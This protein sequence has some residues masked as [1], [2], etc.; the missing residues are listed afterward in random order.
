VSLHPPPLKAPASQANVFAPAGRFLQRQCTCGD[1]T[2]AGGECEKCAKKKH[3]LQRKLS[4]GAIDDPLEREADRVAEQVLTTSTHSAVSRATPRIQRFSGLPGPQGMTAPASVDRTLASPGRPLDAP[5]RQDMESRFGHDFSHVRVHSDNAAEQSARDVNANAYT[6]GHDVVFGAGQFMPGTHHGRRLIAHELTHVVQS[7][8]AASGTIRRKEDW[9][10]TPTG[11]AAL[12]KAKGDFKLSADSS[13]VPAKLAENI[14]NTL[15]YTLDAKRSPAATEGIN[16]EDFYHGH[17]AV[18]NNIPLDAD[19]ARSQL[20]KERKA[21][22]IKALGDEYANV[23][24]KN[25]GAYTKGIKAV[26]PLMTKAANEWEKVKGAVVIYHTYERTAGDKGID[27]S[28]P[29]RNYLTPLDTNAPKSL[30]I[31]KG[32]KDDGYTY[33]IE[34]TFLV[35]QRGEVHVRPGGRDALSSITGAPIPGQAIPGQ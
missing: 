12:K 4:V 32:A 24:T 35:D 15:R 25:V 29:Q 34:F 19:E 27:K 22:E 33:Y 20:Q 6:I 21:Q 30:S 13:W 9:N 1:H 16:P 11:Y 5:L 14:L 2:I 10:F 7:T 26:L 17:L 31:P 8:A 18:P 3:F 28:S 23:T